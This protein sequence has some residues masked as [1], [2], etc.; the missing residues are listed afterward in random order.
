[1][2]TYDL[3]DLWYD[4]R[5]DHRFYHIQN[6]KWQESG[7]KSRNESDIAYDHHPDAAEQIDKSGR[8][9]GDNGIKNT[10]VSACANQRNQRSYDKKCDAV[11]TLWP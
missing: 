6:D 11:T 10:V 5:C 9:N 1:M 3:T 2:L 8:K 7:Y 4:L